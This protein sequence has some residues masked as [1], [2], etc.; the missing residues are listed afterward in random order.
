M[1]QTKPNEPN[2]RAFFRQIAGGAAAASALT[3]GAGGS[4]ATTA[5]AA[6]AS[7]NGAGF[8]RFALG[9]KTITVLADGNDTFPGQGLFAV[10]STQARFAEVQAQL[11]QPADSVDFH[12]NTLLIE[13]GD[14]KILL[15]AGFGHFLGPKFGRQTVALQNAGIDPADIDTVIIS[16]GHADHFA[17]LVSPDLK[18]RFP[19]AQIIWNESEWGYWTS[20]QAVSDVRSSPLPEAFKD[21]FIATTQTVLPIAAS[22]LELIDVKRE[23]EVAP[24]VLLIPAP[25]HSPHSMVVLITSG[26]EQLLHASDT[27]LLVKQNAIAPEWVSAFE[28]DPQGLVDTRLKLLDR[29]AS[30]GI[31]WFGY[32]ASFPAVGRIRKTSMAYEFVDAPWQW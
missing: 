9:T 10:N 14:R 7:L 25:G 24:G 17:G 8:Y 29:A 30:D 11:V 19:N 4:R 32:H 28:Y 6:P 18:L 12:M 22:N 21:L 16:H 27:T 15:D 26:D 5:S 13:E 2:R 1:T 31:S 20:E 3:L 23:V